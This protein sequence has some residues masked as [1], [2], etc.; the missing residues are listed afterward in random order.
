[1]KATLWVLGLLAAALLPSGSSAAAGD[2][3]VSEIEWSV[4]PA[5][6]HGADG[7]VSLRHTVDPG[8]T[9]QD[10][11][12]V[13]NHSSVEAT[14][15]VS[16]GAGVVGQDGVFDV[17]DGGDAAWVTVGGLDAGQLALAPGETRVLPVTIVVPAAATPGDHPVGIVAGLTQG[18]G[19]T[20]T[21]RIG[22]RIHLRVSGE[23][24]PQLRVESVST[25]FTGVW[26]PF[27]AG[28]LRVDYVIANTGNT[29]LGGV[30]AVR[31]Q[32]PWG[33]GAVTVEAEPIEELLPGES[34][35][36]SATL[37]IPPLFRLTGE[38]EV[39]P[40]VVGA[41][42]VSPPGRVS[43]AFALWAV[44][45]GWIALLILV[46]GGLVFT[47]RRKRS[48]RAQPPPTAADPQVSAGASEGTVSKRRTP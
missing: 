4:A 10:A 3:D 43:Q 34:V 14:F 35:T 18:D 13:T 12:A 9:A 5:D 47:A 38:V 25:Q 2:P 45:W 19:V 6:E 27:T 46:A 48:K 15:S 44:P 42:E 29:R 23:I 37:Q 7:R 36:G 22:V 21:H 30:V 24:E 33:L 8:A 20:L 39:T 31:A 11:I 16:T 1:M 32:G 28:R 26:N 40:T 41:D 17:V